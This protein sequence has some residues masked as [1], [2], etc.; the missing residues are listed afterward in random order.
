MRINFLIGLHNLGSTG[1]SKTSDPN[2]AGSNPD[3]RT[4]TRNFEVLFLTPQE[5]AVASFND[6]II[7]N[8]ESNSPNI[9]KFIGH[10]DFENNEHEGRNY[11]VKVRSSGYL[12]KR[13]PG[14]VQ[15]LIPGAFLPL[16]ELVSGDIN[17]DNQ[18][19][20]S[21]FQIYR[22]CSIYSRNEGL[23]NGNQSFRARSD[24]NDDGI[25]DSIDQTMLQKEMS[26]RQGD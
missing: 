21:D 7:F 15:T 6:N 8:D 24:I 11:I 10:H 26:V 23:C 5:E 4:R 25:V 1:D 13:I 20:L 19:N 22:S 16:T 3:P 17:M 12:W 14:G 18:I 2:L 9:G